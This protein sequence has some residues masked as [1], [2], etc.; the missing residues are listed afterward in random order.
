MSDFD[1]TKL[2]PFE[3]F[4]ILL[5]DRTSSATSVDAARMDLFT[6]KGRQI[7]ALP[8]TRAAL[9]QHTRR[10]IHQA[11]FVWGQMFQRSPNIP[12]PSLWGWRRNRDER[13][14]PNWTELPEAAS[15]SGL[16]QCSCKKGCSGR[17][18]CRKAALKCT[19]LC[20]CGGKCGLNGSLN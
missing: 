6:R 10:A 17:C 5:Y 4:V 12:S 13:W 15:Y 1:E 16:L 7:D 19:T 8:P 2:M 18:K 9:V 20:Q 14:E 3:R 11:G